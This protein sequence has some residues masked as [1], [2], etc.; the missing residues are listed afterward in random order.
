MHETLPLLEKIA[1]PK[2]FREGVETVQV[3]L[4]Y[5][6]NLS[7]LH[8]HVNAGPTRQEMMG[9]ADIEWLL[10]YLAESGIKQLDLTGGAPELN[11]H[12]RYLVESAT[13]LGVEVIDRCNLTILEEPGQEGLAE[14]LAEMEVVVVASLPCY[15]EDKVDGQ[16]GSGV[17]SASIKGLQ[18]LNRLGYGV[19]GSGLSLDLVFNP[20]EAVLPP[21]QQPLELLYKKQLATQHGVSFNRLLTVTN[22]PINRFGST[23]IS[24]GCFSDYMALLTSAYQSNNLESVMCRKLVSIDWQGY[25]YDCDFNQMLE[26]PV[27]VSGDDKVHLRQLSNVNLKGHKIR[28]AGHCY[29]CTAGQGSSCGGA[30]ESRSSPS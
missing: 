29:G 10:S 18:R 22:M 13:A 7:C 25:L 5:R 11:D 6:C 16:R 12:F 28:T 30:L 19:E 14:F 20:Q 21:A 9:K 15:M 3:N 27:M 1:F 23:L 4:G 24:K 17:F 8:C 2:L 26:L